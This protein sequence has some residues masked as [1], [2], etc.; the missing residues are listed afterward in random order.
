MKRL[1]MLGLLGL[2][3]CA[4]P[5]TPTTSTSTS[6]STTSTTTSTTSTTV[7]PTTTVDEVE[8]RQVL[9]ISATFTAEKRVDLCLSM[10]RMSQ[11]GLPKSMIVDLGVETFAEGFG[12]LR[13][14]AEAILRDILGECLQ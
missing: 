1:M 2:A 7:A 5:S 10:L 9:A 8:L 3:A 12:D 13:P 11:G 14:R 6:T 4:G